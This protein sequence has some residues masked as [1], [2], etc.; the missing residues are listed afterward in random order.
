MYAQLPTT[1]DDSVTVVPENPPEAQLTDKLR[2]P[3]RGPQRPSRAPLFS[4]HSL[5]PRT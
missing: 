5:S 2:T 4:Y 1:K 3:Q